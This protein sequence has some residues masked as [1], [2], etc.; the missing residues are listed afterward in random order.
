[1]TNFLNIGNTAG[2]SVQ[3]EVPKP[4][5]IS[6]NRLGEGQRRYELNLALLIDA[7]LDAIIELLVL[8]R[9]IRADGTVDT[10]SADA[11]LNDLHEIVVKKA[12]REVG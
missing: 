5:T 10:T 11:V 9:F 1:M 3:P 8:S 12:M 6:L 4:S 7:K 2:G